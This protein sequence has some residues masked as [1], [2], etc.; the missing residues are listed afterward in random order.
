MAEVGPAADAQN[1]TW[2][3]SG[4]LLISASKNGRPFLRVWGSFVLAVTTYAV[5]GLYALVKKLEAAYGRTWGGALKR[6]D[7][8]LVVMIA[9]PV[10]GLA[11]LVA[12][13][14]T[15]RSSFQSRRNTVASVLVILWWVI[16]LYLARP[17]M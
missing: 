13:F 5:T 16:A 6:S 7:F 14:L 2:H 10:L 17:P 1:V 9:A 8:A 4:P 11:T 3:W 12:C 15:A